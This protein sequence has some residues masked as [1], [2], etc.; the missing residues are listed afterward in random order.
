MGNAAAKSQYNFLPPLFHI[1][2]T[3]KGT[4]MTASAGCTP[5]E[6]SA[7]WE[8][9]FHTTI[10]HSWRFLLAL[11][12]LSLSC[13]W[14]HAAF[15]YLNSQTIKQEMM[16]SM[17]IVMF[18]LNKNGCSQ[19]T[20]VASLLMLIIK[21]LQFP[22]WLHFDWMIRPHSWSKIV[23]KIAVWA[24]GEGVLWPGQW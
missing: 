9:Q 23:P 11:L 7:I 10:N 19:S 2:M 5:P 17:S 3:D 4:L 22:G 13:L 14:W 18:D 16:V 21:W 15:E 20:Y 24:G 12:L 8:G 6:E 1:A